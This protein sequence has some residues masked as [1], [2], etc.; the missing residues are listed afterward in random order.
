MC[1]CNLV[2]RLEPNATARYRHRK[3]GMDGWGEKRTYCLTYAYIHQGWILPTTAAAAYTKT[4]SSSP[5]QRAKSKRRNRRGALRVLKITYT[6]SYEVKKLLLCWLLHS[7]SSHLII[8]CVG[9]FPP[10]LL[11]LSCLGSS[12]RQQVLSYYCREYIDSGRKRKQFSQ[13]F[14]SDKSQPTTEEPLMLIVI[15]ADHGDFPCC[16]MLLPAPRRYS[17][18]VYFVRKHQSSSLYISTV[19]LSIADVFGA[20]FYHYYV[21]L[22]LSLDLY[23]Y[24]LKRSGHRRTGIYIKCSCCGVF[25]FVGKTLLLFREGLHNLWLL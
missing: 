24:R 1:S 4:Q 8:E 9:I 12:N 13:D 11:L 6:S 21:T 23:I 16:C 22:R 19:H 5:L 3:V 20:F 17:S 18:C 25:L 15:V 7:A 14:D 2:C 10:Y